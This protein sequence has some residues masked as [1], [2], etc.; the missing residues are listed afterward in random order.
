VDDGLVSP[1]CVV[2][3]RV[4]RSVLGPGVVI[5]A[6]AQVRDSILG[7]N[8]VVEAGAVV[9]HAI[10]D[11]NVRV[12]TGAVIGRKTARGASDA[13]VTAD[14][15]AVIGQNVAVP[16]AARLAPGSRTPPTAAA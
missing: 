16:G 6:G 11:E 10:L 2:K 1:G 7:Q 3:G 14:D 13:P 12:G 4:S 15:L 8:V 5:E 9:D